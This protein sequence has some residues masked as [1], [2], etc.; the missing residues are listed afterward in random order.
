VLNPNSLAQSS[1]DCTAA[2]E[3]M[4]FAFAWDVLELREGVAILKEILDQSH[5]HEGSPRIP[6]VVA[7]S[8]FLTACKLSESQF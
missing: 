1:S 6:C 3:R 7:A 2:T 8:A 4:A 5:L